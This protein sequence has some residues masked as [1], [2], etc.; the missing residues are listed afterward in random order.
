MLL[1]SSIT[2]AVDLF[3]EDCLKQRP[4]HIEQDTL[5]WQN[6]LFALVSSIAE[7]RSQVVKGTYIFKMV[8]D[9]EKHLEAKCIRLKKEFVPKNN[10]AADL[11]SMMAKISLEET[12]E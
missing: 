11:T 3:I 2:D 6:H 1:G 8:Q 5:E 10:E 9:A 7:L 4:S 12:K